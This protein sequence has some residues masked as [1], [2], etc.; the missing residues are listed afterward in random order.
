MVGVLWHTLH[1]AGPDGISI[2]FCVL[3]MSTIKVL[4]SSRLSEPIIILALQAELTPE[5]A[6]C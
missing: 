2:K 4:N 1:R 3:Q 5:Q 6:S